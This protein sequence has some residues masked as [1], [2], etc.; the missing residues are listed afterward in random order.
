MNLAA[1]ELE[2]LQLH[3]GLSLKSTV[4]AARKIG[5]LLVQ[6]K[7]SLPHGH[8]L[9]WVSP[10]GIHRTTDSRYIQICKAPNDASVHHLTIDGLLSLIKAGRK[11]ERR[12]AAVIDNL[13]TF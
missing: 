6:A 4:E 2:I 12:E 3:N 11:A 13:Q 5:D 1:I 7:S 8:Y 9:P 10:L